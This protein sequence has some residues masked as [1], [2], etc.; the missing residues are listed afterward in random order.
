MPEEIQVKSILNKH[1]KRDDWFL[2]DYSVN[3]YSGCSFN[4]IYCYIRGSKYGENMAKTLSVKVNAPELL[5]RQLSRRAEKGEYGIIAL[6]SS[7]EPYMPLEEKLKITRKLLK[8]ILKYRFPVE[9]ATKSNLVLR[10]LDILKEI[11]KKAILPSDLKPRLK[12]GLIILFS[13][14]TLDER[15]AKILEPGA[16]VPEKRLETM[17]KCKDEG[18]FTG[19]CFI[20]VLPFLSDS[21]EQ[22]EEMIKTA[23]KYGADFIFVGGLTLFGNGQADSRTLYYRFLERYYPELV[24]KYKS[25]YRIFASPSKEYLKKLEERSKEICKK[26]NIR[27]KIV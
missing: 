15:L 25:L 24:P 12:H 2:D 8:I 20:P 14:S 9:V 7:T 21:E 23:K 27:Y 3:P 17:K 18:L 13:I 16:P 6:S 26:H 4:C 5:E 10:D 22:L 1:K 19:M 11:D